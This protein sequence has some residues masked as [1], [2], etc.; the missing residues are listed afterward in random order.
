MRNLKGSQYF[1]NTWLIFRLFSCG[2]SRNV[3]S[4][5]TSLCLPPPH[6]PLSPTQNTTLWIQNSL[7]EGPAPEVVT[8][9]LLLVSLLL[10]LLPDVDGVAAAEAVVL[11]VCVVV[12]VVVVVVCWAGKRPLMVL[13]AAKRHQQLTFVGPLSPAFQLNSVYADNTQQ[14]AISLQLCSL[15]ATGDG[16]FV[17]KRWCWWFNSN[18]ADGGKSCVQISPVVRLAAL[19][20]CVWVCVCVC[21]GGGGGSSPGHGNAGLTWSNESCTLACCCRALSTH[22]SVCISER[23]HPGSGQRATL[24]LAIQCNTS[25]TS[26]LTMSNTPTGNTVQHISNSHPNNEQYSKWPDNTMQ[27]LSYSHPNNG[28]TKKQ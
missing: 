6:P 15:Q 8:S 21:G 20:R 25:L 5:T 19:Y 9:V 13:M 1:Q 4:L 16:H 27:H 12:V 7:P 24:Q 10:L 28:E 23:Y 17:W 14:H 11:E 22:C 26:T 18:W 2:N 3:Y